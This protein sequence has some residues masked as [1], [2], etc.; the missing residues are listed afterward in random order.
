MCVHK[1]ILSP[2]GASAHI[3]CPVWRAALKKEH[4]EALKTQRYE[5]V[6]VQTFQLE[7]ERLRGT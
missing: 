3:A 4:R 5:Q 2:N 1:M 6:K 7:K